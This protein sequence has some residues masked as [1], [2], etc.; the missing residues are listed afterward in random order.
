MK[1][2]LQINKLAPII[3]ALMLCACATGTKDPYLQEEGFDSSTKTELAIMNACMAGG[4]RTNAYKQPD[5]KPE[6]LIRLT[7]DSCAIKNQSLQDALAQQFGGNT[8]A[9]MLVSDFLS[10]YL[11]ALEID[12]TPSLRDFL[13]SKKSSK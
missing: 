4:S 13:A 11:K 12:M 6:E 7:F 8:Y 3:C 10:R 5:L 2:P 1:L 9:N